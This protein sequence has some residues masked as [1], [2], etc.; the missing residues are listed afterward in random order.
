MCSKDELAK[1][2]SSCPSSYRFVLW[3]DATKLR[4]KKK[5]SSLLP[6]TFG[7]IKMWKPKRNYAKYLSRCIIVRTCTS[8]YIESASPTC[9][10]CRHSF[11]KKRSDTGMRA[12]SAI[13]HTQRGVWTGHAS[14]T[15]SSSTKGRKHKR[16]CPLS[17][18][19][20]RRS[21]VDFGIVNMMMNEVPLKH[22]VTSIVSVERARTDSTHMCST[23][24]VAC[25]LLL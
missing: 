9:A 2:R 18:I 19:H 8:L 17:C 7:R 21:R 11:W 14:Q 15:M 10:L 25:R 23:T 6:V 3:F 12:V 22:R 5:V 16:I 1:N 24:F 13:H 4:R 20:T